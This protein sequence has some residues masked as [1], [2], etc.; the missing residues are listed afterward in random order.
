VKK[1][2]KKVKRFQKDFKKFPKFVDL[3]IAL[4]KLTESWRHF[5]DFHRNFRNGHSTAPNNR[6]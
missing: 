6:S 2:V 3:V 5:V 1:K 4:P